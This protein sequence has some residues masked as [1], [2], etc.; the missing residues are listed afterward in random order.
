MQRG[1]RQRDKNAKRLETERLK[2]K[3]VRAREIACKDLRD[4]EVRNAS[5]KKLICRQ[6]LKQ[7]SVVSERDEGRHR[8]TEAE[9][10][11]R[12]CK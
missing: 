6:S 10:E 1:W 2:C 5:E 4:I 12:E 3:K 7:V 8:E 9:R 11:E